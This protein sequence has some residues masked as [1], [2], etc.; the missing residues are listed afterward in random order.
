MQFNYLGI[1]NPHLSNVGGGYG[2]P[3]SPFGSRGTSYTTTGS[4][5]QSPSQVQQQH[6]R[7]QSPMA[8]IS[9][10]QSPTHSG[11]SP[12]LGIPNTI[13]NHHSRLHQMVMGT[14]LNHAQNSP[15]GNASSIQLQDAVTPSKPLY[16]EICLDHLWTE[17]VGVP[18]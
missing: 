10:C 3:N 12:L 6:S 11:F 16:P 17:N 9:R 14:M 2:I 1:V 15:A 5:G 13:I 18:K 8:T 7:S 4:C